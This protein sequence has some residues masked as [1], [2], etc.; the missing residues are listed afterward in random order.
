VYLLPCADADAGY[1]R[2]QSLLSNVNAFSH[3]TRFLVE[4]ESPA[5]VYEQLVTGARVL[6]ARFRE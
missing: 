2:F 5:K 1:V 3:H 6:G 4:L